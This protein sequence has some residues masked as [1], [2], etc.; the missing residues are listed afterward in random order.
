[1]CSSW[2]GNG[3]GATHRR[4]RCR[5]CLSQFNSIISSFFF[6]FKFNFISRRQKLLSLFK[7]R[8]SI[9]PASTLPSK[10]NRTTSAFCIF[11][12]SFTCLVAV[13]SL[14]LL[15][16]FA[17]SALHTFFAYVGAA[18]KHETHVCSIPIFS[19][20]HWSCAQRVIWMLFATFKW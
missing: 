20:V 15:N 6:F 4:R 5:T 8:Q 19:P 10:R 14:A 1:M 7:C 12:E 3:F 18:W 17:T 9:D 13:A 16:A 11:S 2:T